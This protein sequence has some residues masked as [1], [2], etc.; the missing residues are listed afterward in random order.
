[1][2]DHTL[3]SEN[4]ILYLRPR[5]ALAEADFVQ[6]ASVVDPHI[7]KAGDLKGIIIETRRFP[8]WESLGAMAAHIRFVR[9]HHKRIRKVGVV[10]DS[11]LATIAERLGSHFVAAEIRRFPEGQTEAATQWVLTGA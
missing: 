4:S 1:L 2:I 5:S 8:G 10:T 3:D 7:E 11:P 9:D 6:L